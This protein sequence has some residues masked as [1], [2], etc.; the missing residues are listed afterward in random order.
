M[1][2]LYTEVAGKSYRRRT[3]DKPIRV[4]WFEDGKDR[5]KAFRWRGPAEE[6]ANWVWRTVENSRPL[7]VNLGNEKVY[8]ARYS[9]EEGPRQP[10]PAEVERI[11]A[12][13]FKRDARR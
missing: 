4:I 1:S 7:V 8:D 10:T 11:K 5:S 6:H 2:S 13:K 12:M 9:D 3:K